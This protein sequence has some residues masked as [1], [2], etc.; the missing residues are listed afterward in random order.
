MSE[1]AAIT[2]SRA[3]RVPAKLGLVLI[4]AALSACTSES[5]PSHT[6]T[7]APTTSEAPSSAPANCEQLPEPTPTYVLATPFY[8]DLI[9]KN[10]PAELW[11]SWNSLQQIVEG[12]LSLKV[13]SEDPKPTVKV[14]A[15]IG[16][17]LTKDEVAA[18]DEV[19]KNAIGGENGA[20]PTGELK[21][22]ALYNFVRDPDR[23]T[24]DPSTPLGNLVIKFQPVAVAPTGCAPEL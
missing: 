19:V 1:F 8:E 9:G 2:A 6:T 4:A 17:M 12:D 20:A 21:D 11:H 10:G 3:P 7:A 16:P 24:P 18:A 5:S 22:S 13:T 14:S 15:T 23:E